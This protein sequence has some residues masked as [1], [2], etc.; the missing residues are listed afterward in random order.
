MKERGNLWVH[1]D[2]EGDSGPRLWERGEDGA[3]QD[4]PP[5]TAGALDYVLAP[6]GGHRPRV[7]PPAPTA[8]SAAAAP[9]LP[10]HPGH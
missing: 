6:R 2:R 4:L 1:P 7:R 9:L 8:A 10:R 5:I 3:R